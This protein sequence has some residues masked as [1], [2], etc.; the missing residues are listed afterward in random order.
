[1]SVKFLSKIRSR[2]QKKTGE[3]EYSIAINRFKRKTQ[4]SYQKLEQE[5]K[6]IN[7]DEFP[8]MRKMAH[9]AGMNDTEFCDL[10]CQDSKPKK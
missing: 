6:S 9:G 1:M 8:I 3:S 2:L 7:V 5:G 10:I 4:A